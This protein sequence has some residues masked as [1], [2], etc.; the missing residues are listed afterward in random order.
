MSVHFIA[1]QPAS[2][3]S[4]SDSDA[5]SDSS[6]Q[7]SEAE[8][9]DRSEYRPVPLTEDKTEQ[10]RQLEARL[11]LLPAAYLD[12]AGVAHPMTDVETPRD[13]LPESVIN[14]TSQNQQP[15]YSIN[16]L[17]FTMENGKVK[18]CSGAVVVFLVCVVAIAL[19]SL[20]RIEEGNVGVYYRNGA[21]MEATAFPGI[22]YMAPFIV[23]V[24]EI[25]IR[26][27]TDSLDPITSITKDGITNTFND[28]QVITSIKMD[29]LVYMLKN[30]GPRFKK[31]LVFDR[32]K[33]EL[34]IF[35]ANSTIDEVY[36]TK[37][38]DIVAQVR[39]NVI[40]SIERL[41]KVKYPNYY[42]YLFH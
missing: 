36:N 38:L 11:G 37:F 24:V 40:D 6:D 16:N 21:L 20:H 9:E 13:I 5:S 29:K 1:V 3:S 4:E 15:V 42:S 31:A 22:H 39:E 7:D 25:T 30:Y 8:T 17:S 18:L 23:E 2:P 19:S 27:E 14:S 26:P 12:T 33:E 41:G 10:L 34:R 35:C 32:I 28:V